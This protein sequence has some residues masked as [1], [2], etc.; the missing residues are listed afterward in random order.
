[1]N[2]L[3]GCSRAMSV[4]RG[5]TPLLWAQT[6][7]I[8]VVA[9]GGL[10]Q[11]DDISSAG[12]HLATLRGCDA[13]SCISAMSSRGVLLRVCSCTMRVLNQWSWRVSCDSWSAVI[14]YDAQSHS[15]RI[16]SR[17]CNRCSHIALTNAVK[18]DRT[19]TVMCDARERG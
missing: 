3:A 14:T 7:A 5:M 17:Y 18:F 12:A 1:M 2:T 6:L 11:L 4:Y 10:S 19:E 9:W 15:S 13:A 16:L 8:G